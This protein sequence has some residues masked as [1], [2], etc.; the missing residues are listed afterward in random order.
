M[1]GQ[2]E[3]GSGV[4]REAYDRA[5]RAETIDPGYAAKAALSLAETSWARANT[6]EERTKARAFAL[7]AMQSLDDARP[8][9]DIDVMRA[10]VEAW[11][12]GH[13]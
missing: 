8:S 7:E 11:L 1:L 13:R 4:A 5:R 6:A 12:E 9:A 10:K 2:D 3:D